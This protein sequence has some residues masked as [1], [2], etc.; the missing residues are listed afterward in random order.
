MKKVINLVINDGDQVRVSVVRHNELTLVQFW[1]VLD[2][3]GI[4]IGKSPLEKETMVEFKYL[5]DLLVEQARE[6]LKP[7]WLAHW[8]ISDDG[9]SDAVDWIVGQGRDYYYRALV[10]PELVE[11]PKPYI[12]EGVI[13]YSLNEALEVE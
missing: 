12:P 5:F 3:Y 10:Q 4:E 8:E 6:I 7:Y 1:R 11:L 2:E 9:F 13:R